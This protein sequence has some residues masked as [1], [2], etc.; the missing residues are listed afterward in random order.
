[1]RHLSRRARKE[2]III[3][4]IAL[5]FAILELFVN[6]FQRLVV[7]AAQYES[8]LITEVFTLAI[9]LAVGLGIFA[10]RRWRETVD[11]VEDKAQLQQ[12]MSVAHDARRL[13]QSYADAVTRG[14]EVE[15][16]RLAREF[17]DDTI[18]QLIFL[19]QRAEL[20]AFDYDDSPAAKDLQDMQAVIDGIISS[21]RS[22]IQELRPPY[23]D[24]L[25]L[26]TALR[27]LIKNTRKRTD[28]LIEFE[29]TGIGHRLSESI[30]LA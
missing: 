6:S 25:G 8:L 27:T 23:L 15:R 5:L 29:V 12:T 14:Q 9:V 3:G 10:F 28:L 13:M 17:H 2:L 11:L 1:M 16:R 19:N 7:W 24:E 30:E 26:T 4:V 21:V 22:F 20:A 18:Q